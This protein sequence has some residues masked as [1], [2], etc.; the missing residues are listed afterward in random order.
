MIVQCRLAKI[1]IIFASDTTIGLICTVEPNKLVFILKYVT[2]VNFLRLRFWHLS[3]KIYKRLRE[4]C[5]NQYL[6]SVR[7]LA[8]KEKL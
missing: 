7:M 3:T 1:N 2:A 6:I 4:Y 5:N 8:K